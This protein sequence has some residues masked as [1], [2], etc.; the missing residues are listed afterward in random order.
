MKEYFEKTG[1]VKNNG[2]SKKFVLRGERNARYH[3]KILLNKNKFIFSFL[4]LNQHNCILSRLVV[5][6]KAYD[7]SRKGS[8][9]SQKNLS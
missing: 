9:S 1:Q 3:E 8:H 6:K 4:F 7:I 2:K 5:Y